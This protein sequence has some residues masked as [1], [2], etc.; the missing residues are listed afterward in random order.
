MMV[1]GGKVDWACH[2][3]DAAT[4]IQ[5]TIAFDNSVKEA[6][7]FYEKHPDETL[8]VVTADHETGGFTIGFS[9]TGYNT[10]FNKLQKQ[11]ISFDEF[12]KKV[13]KYKNE[14]HNPDN[15]KLEDLLPMIKENFGLE[16]MSEEEYKNLYK[17]ASD[18]KNPES[19][20]AEE[21]IAMVLSP[22]EVDDLRAALKQ[23]VTPKENRTNDEQSQLLYGTYDPFTVTLTHILNHKAGIGFTSYAHTGV[24]VPVFAEGVGQELFEGY[25]DNTDLFKKLTSIMG[26]SKQ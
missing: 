24:P 10:F 25:Y 1:E 2:A 15:A 13:D 4:S 20:S 5:E 11:N 16:T 23:S 7:K 12:S 3:N 26:V 14:G 19:K 6:V 21:K 8:I 18:S 9:G 22:K 17:I